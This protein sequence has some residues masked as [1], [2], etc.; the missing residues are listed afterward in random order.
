MVARL[1]LALAVCAVAAGAARAETA[2][3]VRDVDPR[4]G[5]S[6]AAPPTAN[7]AEPENID[8]RDA[9]SPP[10][11]AHYKTSKRVDI[12]SRG[13]TIIASIGDQKSDLAGGH[14]EMTFKLPN[15]FYFI[16]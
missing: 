15:P 9:Y 10:G 3:P 7:F 12:E 13:F 8:L 2:V 1:I 16:P 6:T 4:L 14:A 5:C 11:V